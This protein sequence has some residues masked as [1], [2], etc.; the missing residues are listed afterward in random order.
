MLST[1]D[2][3]TC[4]K[5]VFTADVRDNEGQSPLDRALENVYDCEGCVY[6]SL[7]LIN[8]GCGIVGKKA[9]LLYA[10]FFHGKLDVVQELVEQHKVDPSECVLMITLPLQ[11]SM[12]TVG[13]MY[14]ASVMSVQ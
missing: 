12:Q 3:L 2:V 5:C 8:K 4:S 14:L 11:Y 9:E 10:A 1:G 6:V 13:T 7:L